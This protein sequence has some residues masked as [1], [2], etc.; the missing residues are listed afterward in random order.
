MKKLLSVALLSGGLVVSGLALAQAPPMPGGD[1]MLDPA[2]AP[3]TYDTTYDYQTTGWNP[4][5][6]LFMSGGLALGSVALKGAL[7]K[8]G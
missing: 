2:P 4:S 7:R 1:P 3:M 6:L 5:L 8:R